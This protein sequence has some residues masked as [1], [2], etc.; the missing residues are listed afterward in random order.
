MSIAIYIGSN[1]LLAAV[2][3]NYGALVFLRVVQAFGSAA[4]VSMGA[5]SVADVCA[6]YCRLSFLCERR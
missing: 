6:P 4:V 5:G 2:P 1:I 3:A